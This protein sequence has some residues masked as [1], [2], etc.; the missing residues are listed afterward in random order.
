V[1]TLDENGEEPAL[2]EEESVGVVYFA[3]TDKDEGKALSRVRSDIKTLKTDLMGLRA[4]ATDGSSKETQKTLS[5][6]NS[7]LFWHRCVGSSIAT[8]FGGA[9]IFL[10]YSVFVTMPD[11]VKDAAEK[12]R[13][14]ER[15][16][17]SRE[18]T[19]SN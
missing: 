5:E 8:V 12:D 11:R 13:V 15:E 17:M 3:E 10:F 1:I 9:L 16:W 19:W 7:N 4:P 2:T 14:R 18:T 6:I